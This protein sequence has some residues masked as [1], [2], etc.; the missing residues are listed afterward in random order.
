MKS[1]L[2]KN[3]IGDSMSFVEFSSTALI[4]MLAVILIALF[5]DMYGKGRK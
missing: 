1:A 4:I 5:A 2:A 3:Y